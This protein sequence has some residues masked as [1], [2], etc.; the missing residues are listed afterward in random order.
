M[1]KLLGL[2]ETLL[3]QTGTAE[4]AGYRLVNYLFL[5][6]T[7][8]S[9][10]S[11]GYFG[12]LFLRT[13]WGSVLLGLLMGFIHFSV[14]RI[15]LITLMTKP[16]I[17]KRASPPEIPLR[18]WLNFKSLFRLNLASIVRLVFIGLIALTL[19][20]PLSTLFFHR[21]AMSV[22]QEFMERI[23]EQANRQEFGSI[24]LQVDTRQAHYPFVIFEQLWTLRSFRN[25]V[26]FFVLIV[27][28][29]LL[30]LARLRYG[31]LTKY[32]DLC[33]ESMRQEILID[34]QET[35]EQ[36][37]FMLSK[38]YPS[39]DK[40]LVDLTPFADAPFRQ[41]LKRGPFRTYGGSAD[42][43]NHLRSL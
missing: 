24:A 36:C 42:F 25:L 30:A 38:S 31:K 1:N 41:K 17:D 37:Q 16:L 7:A 18:P 6:V 28:A 8:L 33:R 11:N 34:Y 32:A 21:Q 12:Y 43:K 23:S 2:D 22:E 9:V 19:S 5:L 27:Y 10:L 26:A 20:F 3:R 39:F 40:K 13:W 35:L 4:Q 15:A 14:F 29:P